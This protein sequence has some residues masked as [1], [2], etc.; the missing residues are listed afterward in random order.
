MR[1][2]LLR[3]DPYCA[4][5]AT[6]TKGGKVKHIRLDDATRLCF[7]GISVGRANCA[8][9]LL[10]KRLAPWVFAE[11]AEGPYYTVDRFSDDGASVF[12][13]EVDKEF[14]TFD[15]LWAQREGAYLLVRDDLVNAQWVRIPPP[16]MI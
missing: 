4:V 8:D 15:V 11:A 14:P 10:I 3:M 13:V 5:W 7:D 1:M 2:Q 9:N 16:A 6:V 12:G